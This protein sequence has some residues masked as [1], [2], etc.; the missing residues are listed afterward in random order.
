MDKKELKEELSQFIYQ[1]RRKIIGALVGL[2]IGILILTIGFFKTLLLCL[3]TLLG[4]YFGMR[5]R[6]EEDLKDFILRII[7]ERFK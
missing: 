4:Y 5:W 6:F 2:I 7:P 3:T 1:N